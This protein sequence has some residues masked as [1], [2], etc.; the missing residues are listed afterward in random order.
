MA[1]LK[2][3]LEKIEPALSQ[4]NDKNR[5]PYV[6]ITVIAKMFLPTDFHA[7][8]QD[9]LIEKWGNI[10]ENPSIESLLVHALCKTPPAWPHSVH[11]SIIME[12]LR[13]RSKKSGFSFPRR[14]DA[15]MI[16]ALAERYRVEGAWE[17]AQTYLQC[18]CEEFP[19]F[20]EL[21]DLMNRSNPTTDLHFDGVLFPKRKKEDAHLVFMISTF[22]MPRAPGMI[23]KAAHQG[24]PGG[25]YSPS[26]C[27]N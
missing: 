19:E 7:K 18:A 15:A 14:F 20:Q 25:K 21:R 24:A 12:H 13:L 10:L 26:G 4:M 11:E 6:A 1:D 3:I 27:S 9:R 22:N 17:N 2:G 8:N 16:L 5:R 23:T